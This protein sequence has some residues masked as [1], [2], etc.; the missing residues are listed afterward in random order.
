MKE[1]LIYTAIL[2][3]IVFLVILITKKALRKFSFVG[4]IEVNRRK[5][6]LYLSRLIIYLIAGTILV[7]IRGFGFKEM[8]LALSSI[9]A[10]LGVF[11]LHSG[12]S[13]LSNI[14]ASLITF[15][16]HPIAIGDRIRIIDSDYTGVII[17]ITGFSLL[18]GT[19]EGMKVT[20]PTSLL[21]Q[22]GI[23]ILTKLETQNEEHYD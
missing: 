16:H 20:I 21:M 3:V 19:D 12:L 17:D 10:V 15:F 9:L 7:V 6:I 22:K 5:V 14:R 2:I 1:E 4:S 8:I 18:M 23:E 11:F 13:I